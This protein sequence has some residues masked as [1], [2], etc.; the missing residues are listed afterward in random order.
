MAF[1]TRD[2]INK[3]IEKWLA[4]GN[5]I[6]NLDKV[7]VPNVFDLTNELDR[8]QLQY[9]KKYRSFCS[10]SLQNR[11]STLSNVRQ[12][13]IVEFFD[14]VGKMPKISEDSRFYLDCI[15]TKLKVDRK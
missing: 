2:E 4:K 14:E 8:W 12:A 13:D 11:L 1:T 3:A 5:K 10:E 9:I 15:R 6:T 7:K